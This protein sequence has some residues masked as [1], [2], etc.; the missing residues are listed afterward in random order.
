[1]YFRK[2]FEYDEFFEIYL[3]QDLRLYFLLQNSSHHPPGSTKGRKSPVFIWVRSGKIFHSSITSVSEYLKSWSTLYIITLN[4][5]LRMRALSPPKQTAVEVLPKQTVSRRDQTTVN[6][7]GYRDIR[8]CGEEFLV[9]SKNDQ[10]W[11]QKAIIKNS[12]TTEWVLFFKRSN[13]KCNNCKEKIRMVK[14]D[15]YMNCSSCTAL[16]H[17]RQATDILVIQEFTNE[18]FFDPVFENYHQN[19]TIFLYILIWYLIMLAS[20]WDI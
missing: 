16:V 3:H 20:E 12:L 18:Y 8:P 9:G 5:D 2:S 15:P 10:K 1:M 4:L 6:I 14:F 11:V 13:P 7:A 19:F 17:C